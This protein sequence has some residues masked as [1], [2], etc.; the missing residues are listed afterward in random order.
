MRLYRKMQC[1]LD[2]H[3]SRRDKSCVWLTF[4]RMSLAKSPVKAPAFGIVLKKRSIARLDVYVSCYVWMDVS[5][6]SCVWGT[7]FEV[8]F[9]TRTFGVWGGAT[10]R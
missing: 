6:N 7:T 5:S 4:G 1:F 8:T 3:R 10:L 9:Q 2:E